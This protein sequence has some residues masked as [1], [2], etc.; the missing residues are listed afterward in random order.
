M[1][2]LNIPGWGN[3]QLEHLVCDVNGTLAVDG[4]LI[5]GISRALGNLHDRLSLHLITSDTHGKQT[6]ID[7]QLKLTA[8]RVQ[9][10]IE[11]QQKAEYVRQLGAKQVV[12]IGQGMNDA[13]MLETAGLGI[14]VIS[15]EGLAVETLKS[16][17]IVVNDIFSAINLLEKPM[18]I[19][20]TLR[21]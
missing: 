17:D 8:I 18:R 2:E 6:I 1:I 9:P 19:L 12:A 15:P 5:E 4:K 10:G 16:A 11:A 13:A 14:A 21:K 7:Q 20:A 3:L